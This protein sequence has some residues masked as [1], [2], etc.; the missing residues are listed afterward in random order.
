LWGLAIVFLG[1]HTTIYTIYCYSVGIPRFI[2]FGGA[3]ANSSIVFLGFTC[4]FGAFSALNESVWEHVKLVFVYL[5]AQAIQKE[6]ISVDIP[7]RL[8]IMDRKTI[9][10]LRL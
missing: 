1:L 2:G 5:V 7:V 6:G 8:K 10:H 4:F 3:L 9:I